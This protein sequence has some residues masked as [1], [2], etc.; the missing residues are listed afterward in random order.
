MRKKNKLKLGRAI[1]GGIRTGTLILTATATVKIALIGWTRLETRLGAP[2]GE[3]L[4]FPLI[5]LLFY[6]GWT[7]RSDYTRHRVATR[8]GRR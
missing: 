7:A 5:F 4:I 2:G 6:T 8:Q 1:R 3:L